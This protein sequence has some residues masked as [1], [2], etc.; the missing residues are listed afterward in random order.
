VRESGVQGAFAGGVIVSA[1]TAVFSSIVT[2]LE[3]VVLIW[4]TPVDPAV[5]GFWT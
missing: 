2:S 5:S 4:Y 1:V 3:V